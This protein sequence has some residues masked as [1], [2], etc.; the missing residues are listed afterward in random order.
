MPSTMVATPKAVPVALDLGQ[1]DRLPREELCQKVV[2][3]VSERS[4]QLDPVEFLVSV[5]TAKSGAAAGLSGM[6]ADHLSTILDNEADSM[7]LVAT[8]F[9][10]AK[11]DVPMEII[12]GLRVGRLM[13]L[14]K[15][16][17]GVR[18]IVVGDIVRLL[19]ARTMAKQVAMQAATAPFQYAFSTKAGCECIAHI[20]QSLTD[21]DSYATIVSIDG[22]GA[23][24]LISRNSM[25]RGLLRMENRRSGPPLRPEEGR[26]RRIC[27]RTNLEKR[28]TSL[29]GRKGSKATLSCR[30]C[31]PLDNILHWRQ[32]GKAKLFAYLDDVV[33]VYN[34]IALPRLKLSSGKSSDIRRTLTPIKA[35][36]R[37]RTRGGVAQECI[38]EL[39]RVPR[40]MKPDA[41][42]WKGDQ[43]VANT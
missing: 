28:S 11:G 16:D 33:S 29:R 13:A 9:L 4:F 30:C 8:C 14:Q 26:P 37:S 15:P 36:L 43:R 6:T 24:D 21:V 27:G 32:R 7:L 5:R 42:V 10:L 1:T 41:V 34:Q 31:S 35:R 3:S 22:V 2:N 18:G 25:L 38:E 39:V 23:C 19:V 20:V 40:I 17:G 12:E